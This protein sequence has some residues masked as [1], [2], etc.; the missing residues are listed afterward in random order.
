[1]IVY[2]GTFTKKDGTT[3]T[4]TFVRKEHWT[5]VSDELAKTLENSHTK[6]LP[7]GLELVWDM[8]KDAFR[9]FNWKSVIGEVTSTEQ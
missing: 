9:V 8:K 2:N 7:E 1:M 6:K 5:E 4:M 3:R